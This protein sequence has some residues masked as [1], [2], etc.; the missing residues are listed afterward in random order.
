MQQD[1]PIRWLFLRIR[2]ELNVVQINSAQKNRALLLLTSLLNILITEALIVQLINNYY[3]TEK[4][5]K[6]ILDS[7]IIIID[8][9]EN[10]NQHIISYFEKKKINYEIKIIS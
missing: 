9:R 8:T 5:I 2:N 7:I 1:C 6:A 10:E 3:Y 4:E